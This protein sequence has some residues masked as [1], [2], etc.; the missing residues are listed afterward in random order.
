MRSGSS[1]TVEV[2]ATPSSF[3]VHMYVLQPAIDHNPVM[4]LDILYIPLS[5]ERTDGQFFEGN[6]SSSQGE[7]VPDDLKFSEIRILIP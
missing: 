7:A 2:E 3:I 6:V 4:E 1:G 5:L